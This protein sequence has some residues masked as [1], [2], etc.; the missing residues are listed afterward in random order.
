MS[1]KKKQ[2]LA[3]LAYDRIRERILKGEYPPG[4][5]L[6]RRKLA[7]ELG[8]SLLP[9][10]EALQR[11]DGAGLIESRPRAGTRVRIPPKREVLE[12][13]MLREA[14]ESQAARL[15]AVNATAKERDELRRAGE[16]LDKL[17][18]ICD[19]GDNDPEFLYSVRLKHVRF[20]L[21]IAEGGQCSIL[22]AAIE[23]EQD[24]LYN[25]LSDRVAQIRPLPPRFHSVLA[26]AVS[27]ND[28]LA[29]DEAARQHI[30]YAQT[31]LVE[32]IEL[33]S[34]DRWRRNKKDDQAD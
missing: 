8:M 3:Q 31:Q 30:R 5:A 25:W 17:Y 15:F 10:S 6:S 4:S 2:S 14:L 26:E 27:G 19:E 1:V 32:V 13:Y 7:E 16:Q 28:A 18:Q 12:R 20:H 34:S 33:P 21:R 24:M 22:Q 23:R 29:A 9:V 11:L